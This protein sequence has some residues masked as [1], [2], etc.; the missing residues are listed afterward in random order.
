MLWF[1][2]NIAPNNEKIGRGVASHHCRSHYDI[3]SVY[4]VVLV[5]QT[6]N[7]ALKV[8]VFDWLVCRKYGHN[9][10]ISKVCIFVRGPC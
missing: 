4:F 1:K 5:I 7:C 10:E 9:V 2:L 3:G 8:Y 6:M